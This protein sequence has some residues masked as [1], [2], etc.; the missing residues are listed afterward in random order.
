MSL[1]A[2][3][4]AAGCG[5]TYAIMERL[6]SELAKSPLL[7]SQRV[8]ALTY[9]H[10]ARHR[11]DEQLEKIEHLQGR[12]E[13]TTL[14]S[15]ALTI[16][17]RWH[18]RLGEYGL[19]LPDLEAPSAFNEICAM[20]AR[21][22]EDDGVK[23]WVAAA[24]PY[25]IVDEAQDLDVIRL[26]LV[27]H[28]TEH[29]FVLL[30]FDEFQCLSPTNRPVA[31]VA[32][33]GGRCQPTVLTGNRRTNINELLAAALQIRSGQPIT[34]DGQAFKVKAAPARKNVGPIL[35]ATLIAYQ[36]T[37]EGT[38]ALLSP[39]RPGKSP[40]AREVV[41][42]L[43]TRKFGKQGE[44]GPFTYLRWESGEEEPADALHA[45]LLSEPIHSYESVMGLL[46]AASDVPASSQTGAAL[47]R[48]RDAR[49]I[50][51]F[52]GAAVAA[53][54]SRNRTLAGQFTRRKTGRRRAMTIHQ[55]KNREFDHVVILWPFQLPAG[56]DDRRRL[57][58]N[59]VTRAKKS[60]LIVVQTDQMLKQ[61]PFV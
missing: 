4:G 44:V 16:C 21:L 7:A 12:Y 33:V 43:K 51:E 30:A 24:Y 53:I 52:T 9:M 15:F 54:F 28:L 55:A 42:I 36:M 49:G 10:G 29:C 38:F 2:F 8:L 27:A 5:K 41:N 3:D 26:A 58:Y 13:A 48:L 50:S 46:S 25:I 37:K 17:R 39:A 11:L 57:L 6:A 23:K 31:V 20:A 59:A 61:A 32:W 40:Y 19:S 47:K 18:A 45:E 60:C 35:A 14:D 22:L 56:D 34:A 1:S